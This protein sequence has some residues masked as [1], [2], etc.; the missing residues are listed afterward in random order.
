MVTAAT[1][2]VG[3]SAVVSSVLYARIWHDDNPGDAYVHTTM[4]G[5]DDKG[6]VDLAD[7]VVPHVVIP[8]FSMPYNSTKR[9]L[10]LL[11]DNARFP[12]STSELVV[13]DDGGSPRL[14]VIAQGTK[15]RPGPVPGCGWPVGQAPTT[16]PLESGL[17]D[18]TWWVRIGYLA[19]TDD[20]MVVRAD[21]TEQE[22]EVSK[23]LNNVFVHV[24]GAFDSITLGGLREPRSRVCVDTV[25]VGQPVPGGPL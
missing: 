22:V 18:F 13:L 2:L 16:I 24:E 14:A 10:P 19:S 4:D 9:L 12:E 8:G 6:D 5:L 11:V 7:Q 20:T 3:G 25:E 17:F 21:G 23:G 15:S 1:V